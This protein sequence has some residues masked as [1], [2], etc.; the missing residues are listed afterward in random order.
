[1]KRKASIQ[2]Y[3]GHTGTVN[4]V[5]FSPD[6]R[7]LA[8]ASDDGT[9]KV[10]ISSSSYTAHCR[11]GA[12]SVFQLWDLTAGKLLNDYSLHTGPVTCTTFHPNEFLLASGSAD[13]WG[14]F[15][16]KLIYL[17][18]MISVFSTVKFWDLEP[19]YQLVSS[20]SPASSRVGS[21]NPDVHCQFT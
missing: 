5:R 16:A 3:K 4:C 21:V 14:N 7:M 6:G 12:N 20:S 13:R 2:T 1:M 18:L 8:S 17:S 9:V 10:S 15:Q 11:S 19:P